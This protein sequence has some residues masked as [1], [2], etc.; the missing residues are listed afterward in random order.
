MSFAGA[1]GRTLNTFWHDR[2]SS[3]KLWAGWLL[4]FLV[5]TMWW[6]AIFAWYLFFGIFLIPYRMIRRGSRKRKVQNRQHGE[7]LEA[8]RQKNEQ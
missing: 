3:Y 1:W 8:L 6:S 4:V 7:L 5:L 2:D